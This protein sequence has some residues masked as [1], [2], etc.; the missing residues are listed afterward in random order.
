MMG[1]TLDS[2]LRGNDVLSI[3]EMAVTPAQPGIHATND[4]AQFW[5]RAFAEMTF[6]QSR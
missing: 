3:K 5:I 4:R 6:S 2:R 1:L